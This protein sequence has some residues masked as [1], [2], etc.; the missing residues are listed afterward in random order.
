MQQ[1][2]GRL[3]ILKKR[4]K[5]LQ[6]DMYATDFAKKLGLS[7]ATVGFYLN[8]DRIPDSETLIQICQRCNVSADYLLGLTD[9]KHLG[10]PDK[11]VI[12]DATGLSEEVVDLLMAD[13]GSANPSHLA[14]L[15]GAFL[16]AITTGKME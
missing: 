8:G 15:V 11:R 10:D 3:P 16:T 9:V 4:L 1:K 12:C 7:R 14:F 5:E 6:G 13:H 2:D